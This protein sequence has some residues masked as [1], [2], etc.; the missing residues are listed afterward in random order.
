VSSDI[1]IQ[2]TQFQEAFLGRILLTV[3]GMSAMTEGLGLSNT[4]GAFLAGV[5]LSE[6]KYRY[7][8]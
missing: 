5:L 4:L 8:V 7:Q 2:N 6:T 1:Y 3:T